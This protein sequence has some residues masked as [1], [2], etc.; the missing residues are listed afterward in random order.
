MERFFDA[1]N[2]IMRAL[3]GLVDLVILNL[4]TIAGMLPIVTFGTAMTAMNNVLLHMVRE[5]GSY[6]TRMFKD[7]YKANLRQGIKGGLIFIAFAMVTVS[8]L[9]LLRQVGSRLSTM[10]MI[11]ITVAI[12]V[13]LVIGIYTFALLARYENS[14]K[15]TL[16]NAVKLFIL[17]LPRSVAMMLVW[18]VAIAA[19]WTLGRGMMIL[20]ILFGLTLPG[21]VCALI[22]NPIFEKLEQAQDE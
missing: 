5:D 11:V 2:P 7:S 17:N 21:Y 16:L 15:G 19:V 4:M 9:L 13:A 6:V 1:N 14:L 12:A 20:V 22:Y 18:M 10:L 8:E 3:G